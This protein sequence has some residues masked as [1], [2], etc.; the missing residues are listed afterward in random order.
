V[1]DDREGGGEDNEENERENVG[2]ENGENVKARCERDSY[3]LTLSRLFR[4]EER[5]INIGFEEIGDSVVS[6]KSGMNCDCF[7][8][9]WLLL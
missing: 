5:R 4:W 8:W 1:E 9:S 7:R 6:L 2:K 3:S